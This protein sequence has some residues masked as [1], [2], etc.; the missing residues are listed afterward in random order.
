MSEVLPKGGYGMSD[1]D[2]LDVVEFLQTLV[3]DTD[4]YID[5]NAVFIGDG[6]DGDWINFH[7]PDDPEWVGTIAVENPWEPMHEARFGQP[8]TAPP[9]PVGL[10]AAATIRAS[11]T[12]GST[13][14]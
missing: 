5:E 2:I 3:I 11:R 7:D 4:L 8:G 13:P 9:C 1:Q 14:D 12:S 6:P 10:K